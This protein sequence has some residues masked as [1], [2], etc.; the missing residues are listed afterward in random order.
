M[1]DLG[2]GLKLAGN[3]VRQVAESDVK[4]PTDMIAVGDAFLIVGPGPSGPSQQP[5]KPNGFGYIAGFAGR[6]PL[7]KEPANAQANTRRHKGLFNLAF[8]D[9]HVESI[10]LEQ[11]FST[12]ETA[13]KRWNRD[14]LPHR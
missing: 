8:C 5:P 6:E 13:L 4:M 10:K 14:N 3:E 7:A 11:L 1:T 2:L 12:A 9:S